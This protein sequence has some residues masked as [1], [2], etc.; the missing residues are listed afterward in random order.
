MFGNEWVDDAA[1]GV[2]VEEA[3]VVQD[4]AFDPLLVQCAPEKISVDG[5]ESG[6]EIYKARESGLEFGDVPDLD[7]LC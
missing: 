7:G 2:R 5:R 4:P 1:S 3:E 6:P